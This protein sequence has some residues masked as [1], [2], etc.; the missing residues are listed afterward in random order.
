MALSWM[1]PLP[2]SGAVQRTWTSSLLR[3]EVAITAWLHLWENLD[4]ASPGISWNTPRPCTSVEGRLDSAT[5][6]KSM[7]LTFFGSRS[8]SSILSPDRVTVYTWPGL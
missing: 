3:A 2:I 5:T 1:H 8:P 4:M 6:M 7:N